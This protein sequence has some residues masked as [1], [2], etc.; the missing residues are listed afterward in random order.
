MDISKQVFRRS[1]RMGLSY[2]VLSLLMGVFLTTSLNIAAT[3]GNVSSADNGNSVPLGPMLGL[4]VVPMGALVGLVIT[5]PV[6]LLFVNDK[7]AGVLEY[8]LAVGMD[9]R[10]VFLGYLKAGVMLSLVAMVP[11]VLINTAFMSGGLGPALLGG[12]LVLGTGVSDVALVTI[13]MTAF[14][15]MQRRPTGMNSPLGITI[16]VLFLIPELLLLSVL[17]TQVVWVEGGMAVALLIAAVFF[18]LSLGKL[19]KREKLLP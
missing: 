13:M 4:L 18:L 1:A 3:I 15:S 8:L 17:G 14:S 19:I 9:Q 7:N 2:V 11:V 6:Y 12:A 10:D 16:G 5:T